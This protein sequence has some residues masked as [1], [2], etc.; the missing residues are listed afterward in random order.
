MFTG[1]KAVAPGF[2]HNEQNCQDAADAILLN[3]R[4]GVGIAL[5]ADGH[6]SRRHFRSA[7]GAELAVQVAKEA[8]TRFIEITEE[9]NAVFWNETIR[10]NPKKAAET[11]R[12]LESNIIYCWR[13]AV[14]RHS[15]TSPFTGEEHT[16]CTE[17]NINLED[18][19]DLVA[20]YGSTLLGAVIAQEFWF[21]IQ[22]G[23]GACVIITDR[24]KVEIGIPEDKRL[25]FGRTTSL[26]NT[27]ALESFRHRFGE[28]IAGITVASDGVTDSFLPNKY[29]DFTMQLLR[30]FVRY[31]DL[32]ERNLQSFLPELSRRGSNDDVSLAGIFDLA[33]GKHILNELPAE[34]PNSN[35]AEYG[36]YC[37]SD[38][39]N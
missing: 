36:E 20:I 3:R 13:E 21:A 22:I 33:Q 28:R 7:R 14:L 10:A 35:P 27:D 1:F 31:P 18:E 29:A 4:D 23:D 11:L 17:N 25:E 8:I 15:K 34:T 19:N 6:G 16:L 37:T 24:G 12:Q 5:V 39:G 30:N 32:A 38:A 26:C 9:K 2:S